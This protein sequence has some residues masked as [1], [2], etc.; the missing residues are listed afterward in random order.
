[1]GSA[2]IANG[3]LVH[4]ANGVAGELGHTKVI[5]DGRKC[6]CGEHGCLEAYVGG[7]N[8]IAQMQEALAG[9]QVSE[10]TRLVNGDLRFLTPAVLEKA[11]LGG[12]KVALDIYERATHLLGLTVA[13]QVTVLNPA[14]LVLGGGVLMHAPTMQQR[15]RESISRYSSLVSREVQVSQAAL[16]DESGLIGAAMLA[17][18]PG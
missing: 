9:G 6:G 7:H 11:A 8:L 1:V 13:N 5:L 15:V 14:R 18:E 17:N 2:I 3:Q 4:G 10:M 12:D 16:G